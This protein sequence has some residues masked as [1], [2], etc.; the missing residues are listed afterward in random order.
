[1]FSMA[2]GADSASD[3][4]TF[5]YEKYMSIVALV[6]IFFVHAAERYN[7]HVVD[8]VPFLEFSE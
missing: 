8:R 6:L 2:F 1:M 5:P 4:T 3:S 7:T